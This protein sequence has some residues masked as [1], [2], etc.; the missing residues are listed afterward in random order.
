M[1]KIKGNS[2][3]FL[4]E[5]E[6]KKIF[7]SGDL[8]AEFSDFPV[9]AFQGETPVDLAFCELT[10]YPLAKAEKILKSIRVKQL[11]FSHI[12]DWY[13]SE[14]GVIQREQFIRELPYPAAVAFDAMVVEL[15]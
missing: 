7:F 3:S 11:Y 6:G 10:H 15:H 4:L 12:G 9:A 5:A 8:S 14:A 13:E 2:Y 1:E